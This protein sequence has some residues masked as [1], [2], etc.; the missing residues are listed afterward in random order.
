MSRGRGAIISETLTATKTYHLKSV[1]KNGQG[2]GLDADGISEL[3]AILFT[4]PYVKEF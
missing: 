3:K 2:G 4:G 1:G